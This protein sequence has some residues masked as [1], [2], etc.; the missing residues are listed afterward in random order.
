MKTR[1]GVVEIGR[2]V[3]DASSAYLCDD[4]GAGGYHLNV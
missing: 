4:T 3:D 2:G 1:G